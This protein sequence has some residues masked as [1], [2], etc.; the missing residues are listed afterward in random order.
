MTCRTFSALRN[1]KLKTQVISYIGLG[2]NLGNPL[3][4][5]QLALEEI[6]ALAET[7]VVSVSSFYLT[8]PVGV[9]EQDDFVNAACE[10]KTGLGAKELFFALKG[11]EV[12]MGRLPTHR[13]GPRVI[14]LD[15]LLYG[16]ALID[17]PDLKIPHPEMH[18]RR[19][20]LV[21]LCEIAPYVLHPLYGIT[22]KGLLDRLENS[23]ERVEI[24]KGVHL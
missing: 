24:L 13:L 5:C 19:F 20:V 21:P 18:R 9:E 6:G 1:E 16:N 4:N 14:D 11:I 7:R 15:I 22:V 8:S 2:A 23:K 17:D 10:I 3:K 12:K